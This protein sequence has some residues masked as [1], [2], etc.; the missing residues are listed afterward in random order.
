MEESISISHNPVL[1]ATPRYQ[2]NLQAA[3]GD[4]LETARLGTFLSYSHRIRFKGGYWRCEFDMVHDLPTLAEMFEGGWLRHVVVAGGRGLPCFEGLICG[5]ELN[6]EGGIPLLH[7]TVYGYY[8][9]LFFRVYNQTV[10]TTDTDVYVEIGNIVTAVGQ[11]I[12]STARQV[13]VAQVNRL[14]DADRWAGDILFDFA[15]LGDI[16]NH[17]WGIG[18]YDNRQLIYQ[19]IAKYE[20]TG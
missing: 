5:M 10:V 17:P 12:A 8:G 6:L 18:C 13:N 2:L 15:Q 7:V 3:E 9:T 19:E 16:A 14:H 20:T 11:F 1:S 4:S